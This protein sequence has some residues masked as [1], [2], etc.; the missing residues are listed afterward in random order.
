MIL[1]FLV[2]FSSFFTTS[3]IEIKKQ[4]KEDIKH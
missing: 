1:P 3:S 2:A 4:K